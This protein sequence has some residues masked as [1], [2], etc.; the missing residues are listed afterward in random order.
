MGLRHRRET[1]KDSEHYGQEEKSEHMR[2]G[3]CAPGAHM[4][5]PGT[6]HYM[7]EYTSTIVEGSVVPHA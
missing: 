4:A 2:F 3:R 6:A 7:P 5:P 1:G